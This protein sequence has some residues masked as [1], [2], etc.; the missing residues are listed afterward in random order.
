MQIQAGIEGIP[1]EQYL[2]Y[3]LTR[4]AAF[5]YTVQAIP[6][7]EVAQQW[8]QFTALLE[9]LPKASPEDIS[10]L[11]AQREAE[12]EAAEPNQELSSEVA[13]QLRQ[14]IKAAREAA[15]VPI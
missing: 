10:M 8:T 12:R 14:R 7:Q 11:L 2:L 3:A 15:G 6:K 9:S 1:F 13:T 5:S 4:Q